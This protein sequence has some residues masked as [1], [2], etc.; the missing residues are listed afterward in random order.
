M[1]TSSLGRSRQTVALHRFN[2]IT[3]TP[4]TTT[5]LRLE[6]QLRAQYRGGILEWRVMEGQ[7]TPSD[8]Q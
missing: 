3:F 5:A 6:V 2:K 1:S 4:V 8:D 7:T